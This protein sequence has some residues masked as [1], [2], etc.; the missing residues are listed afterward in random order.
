[1]RSDS[2]KECGHVR[3]YI[4]PDQCSI[5]DSIQ[6]WVMN[7]MDMRKQMMRDMVIKAAENEISG[8][9][10]RIKIIRTLDLVSYP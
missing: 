9:T 10:E 7:V 3:S 4:V 6:L 1:M 2:A 5:E 8:L